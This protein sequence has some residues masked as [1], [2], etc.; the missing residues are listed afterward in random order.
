MERK[1]PLAKCEDCP[2][3][4]VGR[5][6][7]SAG[8]EKADVAFVGEAPGA[9]EARSGVPFSGPSGQLL[10][11]VMA[12]HGIDREEVFVTNACLCRP[13]DNGTPP[14]SAILACRDRLDA[15]LEER[16]VR[17]AVALGNSAAQALLDQSG[18]TKL[19]IGPGRP[20][21]RVD[22]VHV[23]TTLHPAAA[24]RQG[25]LFPHI[26][27]DVAKVVTPVRKW[28]PPTYVVADDEESALALLTQLDLKPGPFAVD[29]EVGIDKETSFDHPNHYDMLCV[30]IAYERGKVLVLGENCWGSDA[31]VELFRKVLLNHNLIFQNGKFD[32]AGLFPVVGEIHVWFDT[33]LASYTFDERPGVHG[34]DYQGQ[35][36]L[37]APNWKGVLKPYLE[38]TN[39]SYANVPR[40]ILYKYN[41]Y[42]CG[43]TYDLWEWY[44]ARYQNEEAGADLRRVHDFLVEAANQLMF[45]EMNGYPIDIPLL[46]EMTVTYLEVLD[47]SVEHINE[48]I[49]HKD[50]GP[51]SQ[52]WAGLNPNSPDQ[53]KAYLADH[54]IFTESTDEQH[55]TY[56]L[57]KVKEKP[58]EP[59]WAEVRAFCE[60]LLAHR[61]EAK[62]YGTYVK[63]VRKRLYGG[64][65]HPTFNLHGTTSGRLACRN[66]NLQNIPR[67][68]DIRRLYVPSKPDHVLVGVD[69]SQAELRVLSY[70]AG[71]TYFR[72]I[73]NADE[74]DL[75]DN[76]TPI[77]YPG[78]TKEMHLA[79]LISNDV[80]KEMRIRIKAFVYGLAYG[81]K[82]Y[83]IAAE[84]DI[85]V[86]EAKGMMD[87]FFSVIPEIVEFR[88]ETMQKVLRGE[89]LVSPWGRHRRYTL[90]TKENRDKTLNEALSFLPQSTASD[91]CLDALIRIRPQLKG[92][93]WLRNTVHDALYAECHENDAEEVAQMMD[94]EM[95]QSGKKI[96]G[97]YVLIKTDAHI[98]RNWKELD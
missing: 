9:Q 6:V 53:V 81:R 66:P 90:V 79:G 88:N 24:L 62:L 38:G 15:E 52:K 39:G 7:P 74:E 98:A 50:Y 14:Q 25:D 34:L 78:Y 72:D 16:G 19:R 85:P 61:T 95:V 27:N 30:G 76:L 93:G 73:F 84:F 2:L 86:P 47:K 55:M 71:D 28:E 54:G 64:R 51:K 3:A 89:D 57:E 11:I 94:Y 35:E 41:A 10:D 20:A 4:T 83:S 87:N 69:Y 12:H 97:D 42:D 45:I 21:K 92:I 77:M 17:T 33:M 40:P 46:N 18:V 67:G 59:G 91:M 70:L 49:G 58:N 44:E 32:K 60:A 5:F 31:V 80:W 1:H 8:P 68:S 22:G 23:I 63:G 65:V 75:F 56:I 82:H 13:P 48:V 26:V 37:G 96:V 36:H 29:I 43:V